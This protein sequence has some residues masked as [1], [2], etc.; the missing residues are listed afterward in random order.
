MNTITLYEVGGCVRDMLM[1][2]TSKDIDYTVV[3]EGFTGSV[4]EGFAIMKQYLID[5]GY[6]IFLESPQNYTIRGKFPLDHAM[7][8]TD[9]DFVMARKELGYEPD[10]RSPILEMGSLTDD[11]ERRDFTVNAIA[12]SVDGVLIDPF[13]GQ[14]HLNMKVLDTPLDPEITMMDDPLRVLRALRFAITKDLLIASRVW[15]SFRQPNIVNKL[16]DVVSEE[17]IREEL[18][19]MFKHDPVGSLRILNKADR[20]AEGL[21]DAVFDGQL[22]LL[23]TLKDR[24]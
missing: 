5:N 9:A 8:G 19:K 13:G 24:S 2:K 22:W 11:L 21:L 17:R 18:T 3:I 1:G 4:E 6:T 20:H 23:P 12:K 15:D 16:K 7:A 10:S 14:Q